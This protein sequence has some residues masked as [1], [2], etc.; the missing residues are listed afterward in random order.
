[1]T[2][3]P[4]VTIGAILI[5]ISQVGSMFWFAV[6]MDKRIDLLSLNVEN[7]SKRVDAQGDTIKEYA[8]IGERFATLEGRVTNH[9]SMMAVTQR[10]VSDL[11]RGNGFIRC[12]RNSIDGE[13]PVEP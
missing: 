9:A 13:Y 1:M 10:D 8:K 5:V 7:L 6:R 3:D 12:N 2:F 11:R 4:T